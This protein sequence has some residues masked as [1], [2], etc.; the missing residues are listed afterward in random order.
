MTA[1]EIDPDENVWEVYDPDTCLVLVGCS[2]D[3]LDQA[4][5]ARDLYTGHL[6][7]AGVKWAESWDF[8][9]SVLSAHHGVVSPDTIL[10]PYDT[11]FVSHVE[12]KLGLAEGLNRQLP[13]DTTSLIVVAGDVYVAVAKATWPGIA[14]WS[15]LTELPNRG[16]GYYKQWLARN[17]AG[18]R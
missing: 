5:P 8:R 13:E 14:L 7:R 4:A 2:A 9:W 1:I 6:F 10:E 12:V 11:R 18:A 16:I 15:P 3:K 17:T